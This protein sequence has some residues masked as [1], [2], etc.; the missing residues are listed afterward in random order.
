MSLGFKMPFFLLLEGGKLLVQQYICELEI[1]CEYW[2]MCYHCDV[3]DLNNS[4]RWKIAGCKIKG[5]PT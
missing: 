1:G 5:L 3:Y 2:L 4:S